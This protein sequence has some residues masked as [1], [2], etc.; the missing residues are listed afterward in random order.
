MLWFFAPLSFSLLI[1]EMDSQP[2]CRFGCFVLLLQWAFSAAPQSVVCRPAAAWA[3]PASLLETP[4]QGHLTPAESGSDLNTT[5]GDGHAHCSLRGIDFQ[6]SEGGACHMG[7][8]ILLVSPSPFLVSWCPW[9]GTVV[10]AS[11]RRWGASLG[12]WAIVHVQQILVECKK[13]PLPLGS[14]KHPPCSLELGPCLR[15]FSP[16]YVPSCWLEKGLKSKDQQT[17][18]VMLGGACSGH[19]TGDLTVEG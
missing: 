6:S 11:G 4:C 8:S 16:K 14:P 2:S 10:V 17:F 5:P 9:R 7:A 15:S 3:S 13:G 18:H 12:G 1:Y 19:I